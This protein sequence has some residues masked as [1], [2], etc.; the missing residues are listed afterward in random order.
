MR[1]GDD[2][3]FVIQKAVSMHKNGAGVV[4]REN[5]EFKI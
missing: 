4:Q 5:E 2:P 1:N 3:D